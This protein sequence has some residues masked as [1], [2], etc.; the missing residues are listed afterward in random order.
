MNTPKSAGSTREWDGTAASDSDLQWELHVYE[1]ALPLTVRYACIIDS[2]GHPPLRQH[3]AEFVVEVA[4]LAARTIQENWAC[5]DALLDSGTLISACRQIVDQEGGY[6]NPDPAPY[7]A[8][9][10]EVVLPKLVADGCHS[11]GG[12]VI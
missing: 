3:E 1:R 2:P 7:V 12:Q 9:L 4:C 11:V 5:R 10:I 8:A 6:S